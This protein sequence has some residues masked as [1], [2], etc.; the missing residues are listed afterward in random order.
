WRTVARRAS[1]A[2]LIWQIY[3]ETGYLS[4]VSALP[5]GQ[6]R[7]ANL[8]K[9]HDRA[10]QFEGFA[11]SA[12]IASLARFVE[13]V[14]KLQEVG[15]DWAPAEP[16]SAAQNAV[17]I[18]SVHKSKGLEFP[19]VVL[20]ELN[21]S[22][23][24]R[25]VYD[26]C[27]TSYDH[28]LGLQVIDPQSN[29]RLNSLA[30]QVIAE[31]RLSTTLAEEM[32]ILYVAT[33][34][35]RDRLVLAASQKRK[36]CRDIVCS[37]FFFE[38]KPIGDWQL[39]SC[40]SPLE[41]LLYG[42]S[43][44]KNLHEAFETG[45]TERAVESGLFSVTLY[46]RRQLQD[47]S[48]HILKLKTQKSKQPRS[49]KEKPQTKKTDKT[50]L[51]HV[52]KSLAW[53]Y[54][55]GDAPLTPAKRSVTQMTHHDDDYVKIDYSRALDRLP[56]ELVPAEGEFVGPVE[57]RLI[58]TATHLVIAKLDLKHPMTE[59]VIAQTIEELVADG[60]ITK[61]VAEHIDS[62][63]IMTFFEGKLGGIVLDARNTVWREWPFTFAV[64]VSQWQAS[65]TSDIIGCNEES[66]VVQGII[67]VL[68]RTPAGLVVIDFKTDRITAAQVSQRADSYRE[69]L[70]LYARAAGAILEVEA[71]AEWL[72]FLTLRRAVEV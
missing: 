39:R 9:L 14:E 10:I 67:D 11:S 16:D 52:K 46:D 27:L 18:L 36:L 70:S 45:L 2:D 1:L 19:V 3:R 12:G 22:F 15:Q 24:K 17:R 68:V 32:R 43:D 21:S 56:I 29:S 7:R 4:F 31:E 26:E 42:L 20:A 66:I 13:F 60:A 35:A 44:Q 6:A 38:D 69:Q 65:R 23:N 61:A 48:R 58:G 5:N 55:F 30:H 40:R 37:G 54:G 63:S 34:R 62:Q 59:D 28:T 41:W 47:L 50:L 25:D 72:Y 57:A 51:E 8:L 33:T 49:G 71:V 53:R 64:P